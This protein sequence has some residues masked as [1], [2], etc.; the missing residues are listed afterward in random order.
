MIYADDNADAAPRANAWQ[1]YL[2][3][4]ALF[5]D[6]RAQ[7]ACGTD[8]A[9]ALRAARN[10]IARALGTDPDDVVLTSGGTEANALALTGALAGQSHAHVVTST[11]EHPS[12]ERTLA[13][14]EQRGGIDVTRI[15][16]DRRGCVQV[17]AVE[18]ALRTDTRLVS[19]VFACNE[20]GVLQPIEGIA[21]TCRDRGVPVHTDAV[22]VAG[23]LPL[24]VA[25]LGVST[26]SLSGHKAGAVGGIG[27]LV[28]PGVRALAP[29]LPRGDA[30][31]LHA[32][33]DNVAG[34]MSL[35]TALASQNFGDYAERTAALRNRL[36]RELLAA[37][38]GITII[39][40]GS[41]RLPNTSCIIF[42]GCE[43]DGLMMGLDVDGLCVSTGSACS[44]GAIEPSAILMGMGLSVEQ[45]R[46][47]V[48][49]SLARDCGDSDID[50]LVRAVTSLTRR[51]RQLG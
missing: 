25:R 37:V 46:S 51:M 43:G 42:D 11:L 15:A 17:D 34:A 44:T 22:Q 32:A 41:A 12:V 24:D 31:D 5:A 3:A 33:C 8:A 13:A 20:T 1:A 38:D 36:E 9:Q 21:R 2:D 48:R 16:A 10:R 6:P 39:G 29:L 47:A 40:A 26:L 18:A 19:I 50:A 7:H 14:L 45:A 28:G 49:I 4:T 30:Q 27:A 35:A 23:R